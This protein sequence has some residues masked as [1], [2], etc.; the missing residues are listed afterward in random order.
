M[1][2]CSTF[3]ITSG[4][5]PSPLWLTTLVCRRAIST[6]PVVVTGAETGQ[7]LQARKVLLSRHQICGAM[8][9]DVLSASGN[10]LWR[11]F[12]LFGEA[13]AIFTPRVS[14][15]SRF[16]HSLTDFF[17]QSDVSGSECCSGTMTRAISPVTPLKGI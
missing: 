17:Y 10:T 14:V 1:S 13:V 8:K 12:V 3:L 5:L 2:R 4:A 11:W 7:R 16:L 6:V 9:R 15:A